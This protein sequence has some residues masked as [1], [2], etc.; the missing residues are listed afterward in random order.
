MGYRAA[1]V[2]GFRLRRP[3]IRPL[4]SGWALL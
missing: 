1:A 2:A 4:Q 3:R